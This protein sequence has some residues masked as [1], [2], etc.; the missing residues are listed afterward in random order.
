MWG[1]LDGKCSG[2][3]LIA[4]LNV[5]ALGGGKG[6]KN[7]TVSGGKNATGENGEW[8]WSVAGSVA[9]VQSFVVTCEFMNP[10]LSVLFLKGVY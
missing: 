7:A 1:Y 2:P 8:A 3:P 6:S 5:A 10:F 4:G 9:D